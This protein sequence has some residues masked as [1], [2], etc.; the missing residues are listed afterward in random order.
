MKKL[1]S[2]GALSAAIAFAPTVASA[3]SWK[4]H[5]NSQQ[6]SYR[7]DDKGAVVVVGAGVG[8]GALIAGPVGAV[9]GGVAGL[10]M[11]I[12]HDGAN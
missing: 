1:V 9:V 3:N 11:V 6:D 5:H 12:A 7:H 4:H 8:A 10:V 2:I